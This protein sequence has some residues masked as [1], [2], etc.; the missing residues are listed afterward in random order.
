M[1]PIDIT[2]KG[3]LV[4]FDTGVGYPVPGEVVDFSRYHNYISIKTDLEDSFE[5]YRL[6]NMTNI[7]Q[8]ESLGKDGIED[9]VNLS[10]LN[11]AS[12]LWNLRTRYEKENIYTYT[13]SILVAVNPYTFFKIYGLDMVKKYEGSI[14]GNLPPHLFAIGNESFTQMQRNGEN[15]VVVISGESGAGK[16]ES[17]KLLLRYLAAVNKTN[18]NIITEQILEAS[19]LL[20][21]FG[22]AKTIRNDNSSRFGKYVEVHFNKGAISGAKIS[23]YL[24]E[25][26]RVVTHAQDE[27][28]YHVFYEMLAGMDPE[29]KKKYGL[30]AASNYYYMNRG[31]NSQIGSK[32]DTEDFHALV[33][34]MEILSFT[35]GEQDTIFKILAAVL[36]MGNV[37]FVKKKPPDDHYVDIGNDAEIKWVSH[38]LELDEHWLHRA[39]TM[40]VTEAR[41]ERVL[42]PFTLDQAM[43]ARDAISKSLY[44]QLFSWLVSRINT[45]VCKGEKV[46]SIAILDIFGFEDFKVNGFEQLC[47]NYANETLQFYFNKHIFKLEQQEYSKEKIAW[48]FISYS[49]NQPVIDLI[50]RKPIGIIHLLDDESNFPQGTD[51]TFLDKCHYN[52]ANSP[53]Y[54]KP[55]MSA[56]TFMIRHYAGKLTYTVSDFLEKNK[57]TLRADVLDLLSQSKNTMISS[58]FEEMRDKALR[59]TVNKRTGTFVM[60]KPR[61]LTV[62]SH[63]QESLSSLIEQMSKCNPYFVRCIKPNNQKAPMLFEMKVVLEQLRYTG[64]LETIKIRKMGFPIRLRFSTFIERFHYLLRKYKAKGLSD[65]SYCDLILSK[66][67]GRLTEQYQIG[68]TKV[69]MKESFNQWL[70]LQARQVMNRAAVMIQKSLKGHL[71]R[72]QF[73]RKRR[74]VIVI[75]KNFMA[76]RQR[77][78]YIK[79]RR[80]VTAVKALF[81][82]RRQRAKYIHMRDDMRRRR[83]EEQRHRDLI[84]KQAQE[85]ASR[86]MP[87]VAHL[88][89]TAEL[90]MLYSKLEEWQPLYNDRNIVNVVGHVQMRNDDYILPDDINAHSLSKFRN[91]F[92]K[93]PQDWGM[94]SEP[95]KRPLTIPMEREEDTVEA[96]TIFKLILRFMNDPNLAGKREALLGDYIVQKG[97]TNVKLRDEI[98]CQLMNQTWHNPSESNL[99]RGWLLISNCLSCFQP[100]PR[101]HRYLL[102]YASDCAFNGYKSLC[103]HKLLQSMG[104]EPLL[105]RTYPP[106]MLEWRANKRRA[107][108]AVEVKFADGSQT[109]SAV[110][111]WTT[112]EEF[113]SNILSQHKNMSE[114][115]NGWTVAL[116]EENNVYELGGHDYVLDLMSEM[117]IMTHFPAGQCYLLVSR[118]G[119]RDRS[120][121]KMAVYANTPHNP[122]LARV[123]K[124]KDER[125]MSPPRQKPNR[126]SEDNQ[127]SHVQKSQ[128]SNA[129]YVPRRR[130]GSLEN[131]GLVL[132]QMSR[133]NQR[134]KSVMNTKR[135]VGLADSKLNARYSKR[136][137]PSSESP[138]RPERPQSLLVNGDIGLSKSQL[139]KRY[140]SHGDLSN[141]KLNQRYQN[142]PKSPTSPSSPTPKTNGIPNGNVPHMKPK[143]ER[144]NSGLYNRPTDNTAK[145]KI[146]RKFTKE[147][148]RR[149]SDSSIRSTASE[150]SKFVDD[151]FDNVLNDDFDELTDHS[152]MVPVIKGKGDRV[153]SVSSESELSKFVDGVFKDILV[154]EN[155]DTLTST[156]KLVPSIQGGGDGPMQNAQNSTGVTGFGALGYNPS[157]PVAPNLTGLPYVTPMM[158]STSIDPLALQQL[159]AQQQAQQF[160]AQQQA[161]QLAAQQLAAQ[162][163]AQQAL[164][165]QASRQQQQQQEQASLQQTMQAVQQQALQNRLLQETLQTEML[166]A[167]LQQLQTGKQVRGIVPE[168]LPTTSTPVRSFSQ[169]Q[170]SPTRKYGSDRPPPIPLPKEPDQKPALSS[171]KKKQVNLSSR[172]SFVEEVTTIPRNEEAGL[173]PDPASAPTSPQFNS[174][175]LSPIS[176]GH[177]ENG[178][179]HAD[180]MSLDLGD[181]HISVKHVAPSSAESEDRSDFKVSYASTMDGRDNTVRVG[182]IQWPPPL[183]MEAREE[184]VVGKLMINEAHKKPLGVAVKSR[185][186]LHDMLLN[187]IK[188][189]KGNKEVKRPVMKEEDSIDGVK[190]PKVVR[191]SSPEKK[192]DVGT[193]IDMSK[194]KAIL[195]KQLSSISLPG[196]PAVSEPKKLT[197]L[198]MSPPQKKHAFSAPPA[199]PPPAPAPLPGKLKISAIKKELDEVD[200]PYPKLAS[201]LSPTPPGPHFESL[202]VIERIKTE[203]HAPNA[204]PYF[205]YTRVPWQL[206]I[207]K[208]F[209]SPAERLDNPVALTLVF[210]Q[211]VQDIFVHPCVRISKDERVRMKSL[212][213]SHGVTP[214]NYTSSVHKNQV[215]KMVIELARDWPNYFSRFYPLDGGNQVPEAQML[216]I[217]HTGVRFVTRQKDYIDENIQVLEHIRFE[218]IMDV[219]V[220]RASTL[221]LQSKW[222]SYTLYS[223]RANQIKRMVDAF[224]IDMEKGT[225]YVRAIKDYVTRESTL[226]SFKRGDIIKVTNKDMHLDRGWLF[227]SHN[228]RAGMFPTEYVVNMARHEVSRSNSF[229]SK[230]ISTPNI[231]TQVLTKARSLDGSVRDDMSIRSNTSSIPPDGKYSMMEFAILHFRESLSKY[232]MLRKEDGSIRG[233]FKLLERIK[234]SSLNKKKGKKAQNWTWKEQAEMVKWSKSPIQ[235]SLLKWQS[236]A[237]NKLALES[238]IAIMK[239]M[240]DYPVAKNQK[241]IDC[242]YV[243]LMACHNNPP[244]RDEVYCQLCKQSTSN[245][246]TKADS[247]V[248]GWRLFT[249]VAAYF[250][251]SEILR[252][253]ILKFLQQAAFDTNRVNHAIASVALQNF[254]KTLKYGGRKNVP[255]WT[256][257]EALSKGRLT[258][259]QMFLLPGGLPLM[260]NLKSCSVAED[261]IEEICNHLNITNPLERNEYTLYYVVEKEQFHAPLKPTEYIFDVTT[262]LSNQKKDFHLLFQRTTWFFDIKFEYGEMFIDVIY[263]QS[264]PSYLNG[265]LIVCKGSS[266]SNQQTIEIAKLAALQ[267]KAKDNVNMPTMQEVQDLLPRGIDK[268]TELSSQAWVNAV[269]ERLK[270][271]NQMTPV[272]CKVMFLEMLITWPLF[273]SKFFRIKSIADPRIKGSCLMAINVRG[274][275]LLDETSHNTLVSWPF[276][277]IIST[278]RYRAD[279]K[280]NYLDL[281]CGNL[282]LQKITRIETDQGADISRI[283]GLYI[284]VLNKDKQIGNQIWSPAR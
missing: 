225:V 84:T 7:K 100:S 93:A 205:M 169:Q 142:G 187:Q 192:V 269:H 34:S 82:M 210:C 199:L 46:N 226:L 111:S 20:E 86:V 123:F 193:K 119:G 267:H 280:V 108:M 251:T 38:L 209:F 29:Q 208:E 57:D 141:S 88:E 125:L 16:T 110:D 219:A 241:E 152:S 47:I 147:R 79:A 75:Q 65:K 120:Q 247:S 30:Q 28:T 74:A 90:A 37:F 106:S 246:S 211:I 256:E 217:S 22:N 99:E 159:I 236:S 19:P 207:R 282:L 132:S 162:Q 258:K 153:P 114:G 277:E 118:G 279:N 183:R 254:R 121:G 73:L 1:T 87:G 257:L 195:A 184:P 173:S 135:D 96:V 154:D 198:P 3:Q 249:I 168:P 144:Y 128:H 18:N 21:S 62:V 188:D 171:L 222:K 12:L 278:R 81:R 137:V 182:K 43:D 35:R 45:I 126:R 105:S 212:L 76:Y 104:I 116:I 151:V 214:L 41:Q 232:E 244:L 150:L 179:V 157:F 245:K 8:R 72:Q 156:S 227:G 149:D 78:R 281:K 25:K 23:E 274:V 48:S 270:E 248:K 91:V 190:S 60:V 145:D 124:Y 55:R 230:A 101:L 223:H 202:E 261:V 129:V 178:V 33:S 95:I 155:V 161:Q 276:S 14:L 113:T 191:A 164:Y 51:F 63:F 166:K 218:E 13:G 64:M 127:R 6:D 66:I 158:P 231:P 243:I 115:T 42:S 206:Y 255:S 39:V 49:D 130:T 185:P 107:H 242:I 235:A 80:A 109:S 221:I 163:Q 31:G 67:G 204:A 239:Y 170:T 201:P 50:S 143:F 189:L 228:G 117:E 197:P 272:E 266:L 136:T 131:E 138:T 89:I 240:G 102:K 134:P 27:R 233:T 220:P 103:Q 200:A 253:Y 174:V 283:I 140:G 148:R 181:D 10:D 97:L 94:K 186:Q 139:N 264:L 44:S 26:S 146:L 69:F 180:D 52:H 5:I 203:L 175:E 70:E 85:R 133:L 252:P 234:I 32:M 176:N 177:V 15:Q 268:I 122:E 4:W 275:M 11:E 98:F 83:T 224:C 71:V 284:Q 56:P 229:L 61:A 215:K 238:F 58:M 265:N 68:L 260:L 54:G 271:I 172:V 77:L 194:R 2:R 165:T 250:D 59:K 160:A 213:E 237:M 36:H 263:H 216:G 259:R 53:L 273:G 196:Q 167:Q 40:K 17:T 112:G 9:M 24:L 262:E 92:L